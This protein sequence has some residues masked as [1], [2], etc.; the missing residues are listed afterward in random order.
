MYGGDGAA[1][2]CS[3]ETST[4]FTNCSFVTGYAALLPLSGTGGAPTGGGPAI[5]GS[6]EGAAIYYAAGCASQVSYCYFAGNVADDFGG[7]IYSGP[8]SSITITG[9]NFTDNHSVTS[10]GA[11]YFDANCTG[12]ITSSIFL[13]NDANNEGGAI[14]IIG[15]AIY[16]ADCNISFN[17]ATRGAGLYC[18]DSPD[19]AIFNCTIQYNEAVRFITE[20]YEPDPNDANVPLDANTPLDQSDPNFDPNDPNLIVITRRDDSLIAEGGGMFSFLGPN[21][22]V[23][24]HI[25]YNSAS[26][27]GGGL[28]LAGDYYPTAPLAPMVKN[29]LITDNEAGRDGA[30]ISCNWYI[31]AGISNCTVAYNRLIGTLGYGGG[32][33]CS[34]AS[35]VTVVDSIIWDNDGTQGAQIAVG[36]GD[37]PYAMP[38]VLTVTYSDVH[39]GL[40]A[41]FKDAACTLNWG[42]P[43]DPNSQPLNVEPHFTHGYYLR[44]PTEHDMDVPANDLVNT[45]SADACDLNM[46]TYTTRID[47]V[48]DG[49]LVDIG[50]HYPDGLPRYDFTLTVIE[51]ANSETHGWVQ[52]E[53]DYTWFYA[54]TV[55]GLTAHPDADGVCGYRVKEWTGTDN[56]AT[57][58]LTNTATMTQDRHV[59]VEFERTPIRQLSVNVVGG[60]GR[61]SVEP[62]TDRITEFYDTYC[63]GNTV[64]LTAYPDAGYYIRG[65]FDDANNLLSVRRTLDLLIDQDETIRVEFRLPKMITV[66]PGETYAKI[67]AGVDAAE[68][69]DTVLVYAGTYAPP[70]GNGI[71]FH[72]KSITLRSLFAEDPAIIDCGK[73]GRAFYFHN[74][75]DAEAVVSGLIIKNGYVH[76]PVGA[77]GLPGVDPNTGGGDPNDPND[78]N[79][80][81]P[82]GGFGGYGKGD[83]WGGGIF[84][85]NG[86][87]PTFINCTITN[88][89]AA[90]GVGGQGGYSYSIY[91]GYGGDGEGTGYGGA[92]ACLNNSNPTFENC[93][94]T[95][96]RAIGG[97]AG[98]GGYAGLVYGY[99]GMGIGDGVGGGVYAKDSSPR[100]VNCTI[101]ENIASDSDDILRSYDSKFFNDHIMWVDYYYD[102]GLYWWYWPSYYYG[103]FYWVG[104]TGY[105]AGAYF[106]T[107]AAAEFDDCSFTKNRIR[108]KK[109]DWSWDPNS[110]DP[111][112][113]YYAYD[114]YWGYYYYVYYPTSIHYGD[115][116]GLYCASQGTAMLTDCVFTGNRIGNEDRRRNLYYYTDT[117][118]SPTGSGNGGAIYCGTN[119][120]LTLRNCC[121]SE[122]INGVKDYE[123]GRY[124]NSSNYYGQ[125]DE[126][127]VGGNGGGVYCAAGS[128]ID[129]NNG[130]C[131][132]RNE[133]TDSGGGLYLGQRCTIDIN[134][135]FILG[136]DANDSGAG[137]YCGAHSLLNLNNSALAGNKAIMGAGG[138]VYFSDADVPSSVIANCAISNN[139]AKRGGGLCWSG[140]LLTVTDCTISGNAAEGKYATGGGFYCIS[141]SAAIENC[142]IADNNA[143]AGFGAAGYLGGTGRMPVLSNCL[144]TGNWTGHDGGGIYVDLACRPTISNCTFTDNSASGQGGALFSTNDSNVAVIDS[145]I[146][147]NTADGN[148]AQIGLDAGGAAEVSYCDVQNGTG[149]TWFGLGCIDT[150]PCFVGD[151]Y[152]SHIGAGQSADSQCINSG[153]EPAL[154]HGFNLL[155]TRTDNFFDVGQID[156]GYHHRRFHFRLNTAVIGGHGFVAPL[157]RTY[158][159]SSVVTVLAVPER[160]YRVRRWTGTD[161]GQP[162]ERTNIVTMDSD[163]N[164]TVEFE[165]AH[166]RTFTVPGDGP[167]Q[168]ADLQAAINAAADGDVIILSEG[169]WPWG[170]FYVV[171]KVVMITSAHPDDPN[172]V[173]ST[174]IDCS[175]AETFEYPGQWTGSG[176]FYFG[177]SSG[178]SVLK[179]LTITGARGGYGGYWLDN[180]RYDV[181]YWDPYYGSDPY[182]TAWGY[183]GGAIYI[184]QAAS[185]VITNCVITDAAIYG[186]GGWWG[187]TVGI[188]YN[189]YAGGN[190]G[191]AQGGAIYIGPKC[192]PTI[193]N[194]QIAN[195]RVIGGNG[196]DG[197]GAGDFGYA[198]GRGGWPG[199]AYGGG[200]YCASASTPTIKNCTIDN[201]QAIGGNA[202]NGGSGGYY[203]GYGGGW[204]TS[205]EYDYWYYSDQ[206]YAAYYY[207]PSWYWYRWYYQDR[208]FKVDGELW[209][210][211][212]Y[213]AGPWYYSGHG[214]GV[215]CASDSK[216]TFV[217]C[218]ISN[219]YADGGLAGIGGQG[220]VV[221]G[222][223]KPIL[224]QDIPGSGGGVYCAAGSRAS[225]VRCDIVNNT[226]E[227]HS[228]VFGVLDPND[229]NSGYDPND[230]NA[231]AG[232]P[233]N[234]GLEPNMYQ[235]M[236]YSGY[237][238][239]LVAR[240]TLETIL[241]DCN[242]AH[243]SV[244]S[245][246]GG[247]IYLANAGLTINSSH[248][249]DNLANKGGGLALFGGWTKITASNIAANVAA[250]GGEGGGLYVFVNDTELADS[251]VQYNW[252]DK[253]G[254]GLYLLGKPDT[255]PGGV[256]TIIRNCLIADNIGVRDGGGI[257]SNWKAEPRISNCTIVNNRA[258][259]QL[260]SGVGGGLH[261]AYGSNAEVINSIIWDNTA[262]KGAQ[263]AMSDDVDYPQSTRL[264]VSYCDVYGGQPAVF[265]G[266]E[267]TLVWGAGNI[268]A[269]P[270]F[271]EGPLHVFSPRSNYYLS[272]W[273][274]QDANSPCID[275]GSDLASVLG[276]HD[277]STRTDRL[278]DSGPVDIGYHYGI[279]KYRLTALVMENPSDPGIHGTIEPETWLFYPGDIAMVTADPCQ[280]YRIKGWIGTDDNNSVASR[281]YVT[282]DSDKTVYVEFEVAKS[283]LIPAQFPDIN[284]ALTATQPDGSR[285]VRSGDTIILS[286][287]TYNEH[288]LDLAGR[289]ITIV[290][291][292]PDDPYAVA[293][294][295][296]NCGGAGRA[297][298]FRG[299]EG[300]RGAVIEGITIMNGDAVG[301]SAVPHQPL[302]PYPY[303]FPFGLDGAAGVP[304]EDAYGGAIASFGSSS[305]TILNCV[306]VNC[307]A[308]GRFGGDGVD[309]LTAPESPPYAPQAGGNGGNGAFGGNGYGGA[310][311]F[312]PGS[313]PTIRACKFIGCRAV[314]GNA[315]AGGRGGD[316]Y[317]FPPEVPDPMPGGG[318][319]GN[320]GTGGSAYGGAMYFENDCDVTIQNCIIQDCDTTQ[321]EGNLGGD[322]GNG[323][324]A[325]AL[326]GNGGSG[327]LNGPQS[328]YGAVH[329]G[330]KCK[331]AVSDTRITNNMANDLVTLDVWPGGNGGINVGTPEDF[332]LWGTPGATMISSTDAWVGGNYYGLGCQVEMTGCDLTYNIATDRGGAEYYEPNCTILLYDCQFAYNS[333][334]TG[335]SGGAQYFGEFC[336][337]DV[338][339]CNYFNN[340]AGA[341][342]GAQSFGTS[343]FINIYDCGFARNLAGGNGGGVF[344]QTGCSLQ[345]SDSSF[346]DNMADVN[347]GRGG[348]VF[349]WQEAST[350]EIS[351]TTFVGNQAAFGG[352]LHW[353]GMTEAAASDV[354]ISGCSIKDNKATSHG[355]GLFWIDG[356]P[357]IE[358]TFIMG[359]ESE[360]M[361]FSVTGEN[362]YGG[363]GGIF[364]WSSDPTIV[365]CHITR[366]STLGSGGGAYFGGD[367]KPML[368]N[369]LVERNSAVADGGG[370]VAYWSVRPTISNCTIVDNI[371]YDTLLYDPQA[372]R[373]GRGGG[374]A[375]FYESNI[376]LIDSI[377]WGNASLGG[378]QIALG[379]V[380]DPNASPRPAELTVSY[381]LVEGWGNPD[382]DPNCQADPGNLI[383]NSLIDPCAVFVEDQ[384][385]LN[386]YCNNINV[387]PE[388]AS[389]YDANYV[390]FYYLSQAPDQNVTSLC[391]DA[392]SGF[393]DDPN[394]A[395]DSYTTCTCG[396][397]DV[398]RVDMGYHYSTDTFRLDVNVVTG[399][400]MCDPR[401]ES[402]EPVVCDASMCSYTFY[403]GMLVTLTAEPEPG[404]RVRGWYDRNNLLIST[405]ST[406]EV[407][408]NSRL[409]FVVEFEPAQTFHIPAD[410]GSV[411]A[412]LTATETD[413]TYTVNSGDR[414]V[415][416]ADV[417]NEHS[418]DFDGRSITIASVNPDDPCVVAATIIDCGG[419]GPAFIFRGG[420][421]PDAVIDGLTIING[422]ASGNSAV[423]A[424]SG[425]PG[426]PGQD[427]FGGAI[428][429][430][431]P[432]SPTISNCV[433]RDCIARGQ[434]GGSGADGAGSALLAGRPGGDGGRGGDGYG[435]AFYFADGSN[436][437]IRNCRIT[438]CRAIGG[439]GG[440]GGRGGDGVRPAGS[441]LDTVGG[442]AGGIAGDGGNAY[443]GAMYFGNDCRVTI[444]R[445]VVKGC[446]T[447]QGEG[448]VGGAG[449]N[450]VASEVNAD[451]ARGGDGGAGGRN[452]TVSWAGAIYCGR[453]STIDV[454][455]ASITDNEADTLVTTNSWPG[456]LG[457]TNAA[458][459]DGAP[460]G[461]AGESSGSST[462]S[463]VGGNYYDFGCEVRLTKCEISGNMTDT[464]GGPAVVGAEYYEPYCTATVTD[465]NFINNVSASSYGGAQHFGDFSAAELTDCNYAG[466]RAQGSDGGALHFGRSCQVT[467]RRCDFSD[468]YAADE[469]G[470]VFLPYV[471]SLVISDSNFVRNAA[472]GYFAS[473]GALYWDQADSATITNSTFN[474]NQ[475]TFGGAICWRGDESEDPNLPSVTV[476]DCVISDNLADHGGGLFWNEGAPRIKGCAINRNRARGFWIG[477]DYG[478]QFGDYFYGGGGGIFCWGSE[479]VIE[480]CFV[481]DNTASGSGGGVY[482]GGGTSWPIL[483]NCLVKGNSAVLDGGGVVSYWFVRPTITSC[484]IAHNLAFDRPGDKHG[485]GGGL[486]CSYES[487]TNLINSIL[488]GNSGTNGNQ[489]ALGSDA[490]PNYIQRPAELT[491]S[492]CDIQGGQAPEAIW[493]EPGRTLNWLTGNL[494]TDPC[495]VG[496]NYFLS[497]IDAGQDVNSP[498]L[499]VGSD[500]AE[501]LGLH[502]YSTRT[503]GGPDEG[504]L[505]LGVHYA[506]RIWHN[507]CVKIEGAQHGT[508]EIDPID[509]NGPDDPNRC[510]LGGRFLRYTVVSLTAQPNDPTSY[511]VKWKGTD[512]DS[513]VA[514]TNTA[515]MYSNRTVTVTFQAVRTIFVPEHFDT[516][517]EA[518]QDAA[519]GDVIAVEPGVY[520][521]SNPDGIDLNG[522][523]ITLK[524]IR[525]DDPNFVK[526]TI[527]D[528]QQA[529]RAFIF[530]SGEDANTVIDGFTIRNGY[531]EGPRGYDGSDNPRPRDLY[532]ANTYS[533]GG[534]VGNGYGGA[535]YCGENTSPVIRRCIIE[536]CRAIGPVG[537]DGDTADDYPDSPPEG[538]LSP[539]YNVDTYPGPVGGAGGDAVGHGCGGAIY[540]GY[541][542]SPTIEDCNMTDNSAFGGRGG[543]GGAGGAGYRTG[544]WTDV[545]YMWYGSNSG[546]RGGSGGDANGTGLGGAIYC[547]EMSAPVLIGCTFNENVVSGGA[548]G[549]GGDGGMGRDGWYVDVE[550]GL[551]L[552]AGDLFNDGGAGGNGG[553]AFGVF[554][555]N[556]IYAAHN[557]TLAMSECSFN[558][559]T[560]GQGAAGVGGAGGPVEDWPEGDPDNGV[561]GPNGVRGIEY[562]PAG[563]GGAVY[564]EPNCVVFVADSQFNENEAVSSGGAIYFCKSQTNVTAD[565]V[566][567]D[568][569]FVENAAQAG[570]GGAIHSD[571]NF[572]A[573]FDRCTFTGNISATRGGAVDCNTFAHLSFIDCI[574]NRNVAVDPVGF[575]GRGGALYCRGRGDPN[576]ANRDDLTMER[577][578]FYANA[579]DDIGGAIF[580]HEC[581]ANLVH[582]SIFNNMAASGGGVYLSNTYADDSVVNIIGSS[583]RANYAVSEAGLGTGGGIVTLNSSLNLINSEMIDNASDSVGGA[584]AFIGISRPSVRNCL[585]VGNFAE[586]AGGAVASFLR[587]DPRIINCTFS[588]N[589]SR[590][591]DWPGREGGSLYYDS[592]VSHAATV[593]NCIF[594]RSVGVAIYE[595][596]VSDVNLSH[597]L[598][599]D[600]RDGDYYNGDET[601]IFGPVPDAGKNFGADSPRFADGPLGE[602][603]LS[604][605]LAGQTSDSPAVDWGI[606]N[607]TDLGDYLTTRT[608]HELDEGKPDLGYHYDVTPYWLTIETIGRGTVSVC[609][610]PCLAGTCGVYF[611]PFFYLFAEPDDGYRVRSWTGT[612]NDPSWNTNEN[613]I[614]MRGDRTVTVEFEPDIRRTL[615]VPT[616]AYMTVQEAVEDAQNGDTVIVHSGT[617]VGTG[618]IIDKNI[619]ITSTNP[620]DPQVVAAT[621]IDC[622]GDQGEHV[623][624]FVLLGE[625]GGTVVLN[626]L[627]IMNSD[628]YVIAGDDAIDAND[629]QGQ[630]PGASIGGGIIISG[631]HIVANCVV[632]NCIRRGGQAGTSLPGQ[633]SGQTGGAGGDGGLAAGAGIFIADGEPIIT[634]VLV[635]NCRVIGGGGT[636]G[637]NGA[638]Y[639]AG[640]RGG[641]G[642]AALGAGICVA[643]GEPFFHKVTVRGCTAT[644][645]NAG[646][647]GNGQNDAD[648]GDGGVP[649]RV[650]GAGIFCFQ[651]STAT[652][653]DCTVENCRAIGGNAGNGGNGGSE[654]YARG[655]YGGLS[656]D[657]PND[658]DQWRYSV[659]GA[660]VYCDAFA[661]ATFTNCSFLNNVT[662]SS[663]GGIG[664]L[665]YYGARQL[666]WETWRAPAFGAGVYC[667]DY[668]ETEF[669]GCSFRANRTSYYDDQ[670]TGYG[671]GIC[672][673]NA[674]SAVIA[675][676]DFT[677]NSASVGGAIYASSSDV[678]VADCNLA[679][680][681]SY[682]GGA[683]ASVDSLAY[684]ARCTISRN[685]ASQLARLTDPNES[686]M[687]YLPPGTI[688]GAG[689]GLYCFGSDA[690]ISDTIITDNT[691]SG[692]GA[693][694]YLA[695][696]DNPDS[697]VVSELKNCLITRNR[698]ARDGGGVSCNW[699][700]QGAIANCTIADNV[701]TDPNAYGGG[702]YCSYDSDVDVIDSIIWANRAER[703]AQVAVGGGGS[704]YPMPSALTI[705]YTDIG[706]PYDPNQTYDFASGD[707]AASGSAT[708]GGTVLV[709]SQAVYDQFGAQ[710]NAKVIVSLRE[711]TQLRTT[712][713]WDSPESVA[714]LRAE[715][716]ARQATVL[717]TL[718]PAEFTLRYRYQNQTAFSGQITSEGLNRLMANPLV[719]RLEP[720]RQVRRMLAQA[721]P[722]ANALQA[723]QA[724]DG[725]GVA[726]AIVD[727]GV[728]YTHPMLGNNGFPNTKVIGGYDTGQ[729]DADP[730]PADD[731][732]GTACAGIAAGSLGT[733]GDYI[734]GVAYN[735]KIYA[736]KFADADGLLL[737]DAAIAAW[738]WCVTHRNDD[739]QNP[740]MVISNSWGGFELY[741]NVALAE[742]ANPAL[743]MAANNAAQVGITL[744]AAAG[745]EYAIDGIVAPAALG[746]VISVGAVYDTNDRVTEYS[747]TD[748]ILDILA[749]GDP[750]YTTD[751]VGA[752]GY[753]PGNYVTGFGGTS[754]ACPFAAGAVACLQRA[755]MVKLRSYLSPEEVRQL[756]ID[757]GDPV[758]DTKVAITKPRVNL[759]AAIAALTFGPPIYL[760]EDCTLNGWTAPDT[761]SYL[762]WRHDLWPG[763]HNL[764]EDPNFVVGYYLSQTGAGQ[765]IDSNCVDAGSN[766]VNH[767]DVELHPAIYTTRTD[768]W[769]DIGI[770]D[771]GYHYLI[772]SMPKLTVVIVDANG[773]PVDPAAADGFVEPSGGGRY[774]RN[775]VIQLTAYPYC[776]EINKVCYRVV[777]TGTDDDTSTDPN[778]T[779]TMT[780]DKVVKVRFERIRVYHLATI[781]LGGHGAILPASGLQYEGPVELFAIP[782][783]DYRVKKWTGTDHDL[784]TEPN[785]VVTMTRDKVVIVSF[786][787]PDIIEVSGDPNA[788]QTAIN[789]AR[790]GDILIVAAGVYDANINLRGKAITVTSTNPDDPNVV[791]RTVVDCAQAGRGFTFNS[792]EDANTILDGL[793]I[794]NGS[795]TAENG[796][797]IFIDSN[798]APTIRNTI[799]RDCSAAASAFG[800]GGNGGGIYVDVNAA[801]VFTNCSVINCTADS[802]GGGAYCD[803]NSAAVFKRCSFNENSAG[804]GGG[805]FYHHVNA[806]SEVNDCNL[807]DN[808]AQYGAGV[809]F[810]ANSSAVVFGSSFWRNDA[811]A[812]GGAICVVD[813]NDVSIIDCNLFSN[814]AYRGAGLYCESAITVTISRCDIRYNKAPNVAVVDPNDP[815]DPN[816]SIVGQGGGIWCWATPALISDCVLTHNVANTSG[817]GIYLSGGPD[818]PYIFNCLIINNQAGRDGGGISANWYT[819]PVIGNCTLSG[820]ACPGTF[821]RLNGNTGF[822][823]ALYCGYGNRTTVTD[824]ILWNNYALDGDEIAIGTGF[825]SGQAASRLTISYSNI[826]GGI[827][828]I[829]LEDGCPLPTWAPA[830]INADPLFATGPLGD[831]YLSQT[832]AGQPQ[833]SPS[834]D[835]GSVNASML[836]LT[837]YT[838]RTDEAFD[839]GIVDMGYHYPLSFWA[840]PCRICDLIFDGIINF[841][842]YAVFAEGWLEE[843]CS[844]N[845]DWCDGSDLSYDTYV[846]YTDLAFFAACWLVQDVRPPIPDPSRWE[847]EPYS[848]STTPPFGIRMRAEATYDAWGWG[849]QY[850]FQCVSNDS[851]DSG[852]QTSRSYQID[853]LALGTELCFRVKAREVRPTRPQ[854]EWLETRWSVVRCALVSGEEPTEDTTPPAPAPYIIS[855]EPNAPNSI[856]L[857]SSI[858]YDVHQVEYMFQNDTLAYDSGWL[859]F[860][861]GVN[862]TWTDFDLQPE[863]EYCYR[864]KARDKSSKQNET[865]W[866]DQVCVMTPEAPDVNAPT[867][868][869][870]LWDYSILDVNGY[871]IDGTPHQ[872][873][874]GPDPIWDYYATM[875]A[876]PT[877]IDPEGNGLEFFFECTNRSGFSSGWMQFAGPPY[878]YT[879]YVGLSGQTLYFRVKARDRS[880]NKN[881]TAWS[882]TLPMDVPW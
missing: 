63:E 880:P 538:T 7:A 841:L 577:T 179:G 132:F 796:G 553:S 200:I 567:V 206:G 214:G 764:Q 4:V 147:A 550:A 195:C 847:I 358:N 799:I 445:C 768:A 698:A 506:P 33:Y 372:Y 315:G 92:V 852:W 517:E 14:F 857:V 317:K 625:L 368:N 208:T 636:D 632:K 265:V 335:G 539:P 813:A 355:G 211:W 785:N 479:A 691:T 590:S 103:M 193:V 421:G 546:G 834:V 467:I 104:G 594:H 792:G 578:I 325:L 480:D 136:N 715:I 202:G 878:I 528:C 832:A 854:D 249:L 612:D 41:A 529:G 242:V 6:C 829:R 239:G 702:L 39:G 531:V 376:T 660:G 566:F 443:G 464:S 395:M 348:A 610:D 776:D 563:Y 530:Q 419:G 57:K 729:G 61:F 861:E 163:K 561:E 274:L 354:I 789:D 228:G 844:D 717:A 495:F 324:N 135:A 447:L 86:S 658:T 427:A 727:S 843:G 674:I 504:Q 760:E 759:G 398:G 525:P 673:N 457:G 668:S 380:L 678:N 502:E 780:Q 875:R 779:V 349:F 734:G 73:D 407:L 431:G 651:D 645:G 233:S 505:D 216:P 661:D 765:P 390:G 204:S 420:E 253:S 237:G 75:E 79:A 628:I 182:Q 738:D 762:E 718:L 532:D 750:I 859:T 757:T 441:P 778:N 560:Y 810:D 524:S 652:F 474:S 356:A 626:G 399:H 710:G 384:G 614:R 162:A 351:T 548:G 850:Y 842:D 723:R 721:I 557:V 116:A 180:Y 40:S 406:L 670:W 409:S 257:S 225:F 484:T 56:D 648:G 157:S 66:G 607:I 222:Q 234:P 788:I 496:H 871:S 795:V 90:G 29:C 160:G 706:P 468:S 167:D 289:S 690:L 774:P 444:N 393:A 38:S 310:L 199:F 680:N 611:G 189:G 37:P 650:L 118:E 197:G 735:A 439:N 864:V 803:V 862:P 638:I 46:E 131:I 21:S 478:P 158:P 391:V 149:Q 322:G 615:E 640:G 874:L 396:A 851:Y 352:G 28:Y 334:G 215:Y 145:I 98:M 749:P 492:Y 629:L 482:L 154:A 213:A 114:P 828:G 156:M 877:T 582:C 458:S 201:C 583:I 822:G 164:V 475:A 410:F 836:G 128:H 606:G 49:S 576:P 570:A 120:R 677:G 146:W 405:S 499:D 881:E 747:N 106:D 635:E 452:G 756:L 151:Y 11:V 331:V 338:N 171:D 701:A 127:I 101:S 306:F 134:D 665:H 507:L 817:G 663:V 755:A 446:S 771:M 27:S 758:T 805:I 692:S 534:A 165:F 45:G 581:D 143:P 695:G 80:V 422:D 326:G 672:V 176:G 110:I 275:A 402:V 254:G 742:A 278:P 587:A 273:P 821:S 346:T 244:Y 319:G 569:L 589:R 412:A 2:Y 471:R 375:G 411:G 633:V 456:G 280:G 621:V 382:D 654:E 433:I 835:T 102:Y 430:F 454:S 436:P 381:S 400:G 465:C 511:T 508:V 438:N 791:A 385:R 826:K 365:N 809:F 689:G 308:R 543:M 359:N 259:G 476:L 5:G 451:G 642:G 76:G 428:I 540:C 453:R 488:W 722:L 260:A 782:D 833:T 276:M 113:G 32:L 42:I 858:S 323:L 83:S 124:Y 867:P 565:S 489:I 159:E 252:A 527:I 417:H 497:Q 602:F 185:P 345:M 361:F 831:Y 713:D 139:A 178:S 801:P 466:N 161:Y 620:D 122:N 716:A 138:A 544:P 287:R 34:Y 541:N 51:D 115:G 882:Q 868:D 64:T 295:I 8:D 630:T 187:W 353:Y 191:S 655:G 693:G 96:N 459:V 247:G 344:L 743:T 423:R 93:T 584:V 30:G 62:S 526:A 588:D 16:V 347:T 676:C 485:R 646:N 533:G 304:G 500:L 839:K 694:V 684:I 119:S 70:D 571:A 218:T 360:G 397:N 515:T 17:T 65:W 99:R 591:L 644:G 704:A 876:D 229:P 572:V 605:V 309:G 547:D 1:V 296:I 245:G 367:G 362:I 414:I 217:E 455:D 277:Y 100:F 432:S 81:D 89:M 613:T 12:E 820:N 872:I 536:Q 366:N 111:N 388:F 373:R 637:G 450:G 535:I 379:G 166:N 865:F 712:T 786:E 418:L 123:R 291:E 109:W 790:D 863:T 108:G 77:A 212:G 246:F 74:R 68:P 773:R 618:F 794:I 641:A 827:S 203:G 35:N 305:P 519:S 555:G 294:T 318:N 95:R 726:V 580:F 226:V 669:E 327:G 371:V 383:D 181:I 463:F 816:A 168:Y 853:G 573:D 870:M 740:I 472:Y 339:K 737:T 50:Y 666:P 728:D 700:F 787:L 258:I 866:S 140:D 137:L 285:T 732:H 84:C 501:N 559:N 170:G 487:V 192:S 357:T 283:F 772:A 261:C 392:G 25:R 173:A 248:V 3:L 270:L 299:G 60:N 24:C 241:Q 292:K 403:A 624:G 769:G 709:D 340:F 703:G 337:A 442:G 711:P 85:T 126:Y 316:G 748:E 503:D 509:A 469:G 286:M 219:G 736:L 521:V 267:C 297:F 256:Q 363:G 824:S 190:G 266:P 719:V 125:Y 720:A 55:V 78:P 186:V 263:L 869:P 290:S 798:S 307:M 838:T 486:A 586:G 389:K 67:Q 656:P 301:S 416:A 13:E 807:A 329:Y 251:I 746:S 575:E 714:T 825:D 520:Y 220:S 408:M 88:C 873:W 48:K 188:G 846:D 797:G 426:L 23:D 231:V 271:T 619:T 647:G 697:S 808:L 512:D 623:G 142:V 235:V 473:G 592:D 830:N 281:N 793:T 574:F 643:S 671:A 320:A 205:G 105:G 477:F 152:L 15:S 724:Y 608:D 440:A 413:G 686:L 510:P 685:T 837:V 303:V 593:T 364:C 370:I 209:E 26:T 490:D 696:Y 763:S 815:N 434:F 554:K 130:T 172:C 10:G 238:G 43:A 58:A 378:S 196:G 94:I 53:P 682:V 107:G 754:A 745:N 596:A 394:I 498:C 9:S 595:T 622:N 230:P 739:P 221:Y 649:G 284:T 585:F 36:T 597:N 818:S 369:C 675:G 598:F 175:L 518:V 845:N 387:D 523:K 462:L 448:N 664:G 279:G 224:H 18:E 784:S 751:I 470:A 753:D 313:A 514:F 770:V 311:Y 194:C 300:G 59:T 545:F 542:S 377:L 752:A 568:T 150:D 336:V 579:A 688:L 860:P 777:W 564:L 600:N 269:E 243:N 343:C 223:E 342:G 250:G 599:A 556:A 153:S 72:G 87:S 240:D 707:G 460:V 148:S 52:V 69:G 31:Q 494:D 404:Y 681:S 814:T 775:S 493:V 437:T 631:D 71:D 855:A 44:Q 627:T 461:N 117:Q 804:W 82:N 522:K 19:S 800:I 879:T 91:G 97:V 314:G 321:G 802:D 483:R 767:P 174:I 741:N 333:A 856:V 848:M 47:G 184:D 129:V 840:E 683:V 302:I 549:S 268:D 705:A 144:V 155:T 657:N 601:L 374:L 537:G 562:F 823:G 386:W 350:I 298:I 766:D 783:P 516:I 687:P 429:S 616:A 653:I 639:G 236:P 293:N 332:S 449:G 604:Q 435:G 819:E 679:D 552:L 112:T 415:L 725:S 272:H 558:A 662:E 667:A 401:P 513:S 730:M 733:V 330:P 551:G 264:V 22:I 121:I 617:H 731:A 708:A 812:D 282:M 210:H 262:S 699:Y 255:V 141:S 177:R 811:N 481:T 609:T 288:D 207:Y 634:N 849:I 133:S 20:Y 312:A 659:N 425:F 491:V 198:G 232:H 183:G 424:P 54:G 169:V 781:V 761:N 603:Y 341:S 328:H 744:L 806:A 227:D